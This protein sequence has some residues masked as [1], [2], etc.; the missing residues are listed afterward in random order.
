MPRFYR[1]VSDAEWKDFD[2]KKA[3]ATAKNTL[4]GKQVP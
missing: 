3:F 4:E 1:V 2:E